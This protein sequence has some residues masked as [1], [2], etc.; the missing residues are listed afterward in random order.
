M[1]Q[2]CKI[3]V[4]SNSGLQ[5]VKYRAMAEMTYEAIFCINLD[6]I[7]C[8]ADITQAFFC[9]C[10]NHNQLSQLALD[11]SAINFSSW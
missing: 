2:C 10:H 5:I 6:D 4:V 1:N 7:L 8:P 3:S 9:P 11:S